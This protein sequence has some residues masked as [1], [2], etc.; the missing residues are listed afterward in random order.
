VIAS[1]RPVKHRRGSH[2]PSG[3]KHRRG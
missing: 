3:R 1:C 2:C